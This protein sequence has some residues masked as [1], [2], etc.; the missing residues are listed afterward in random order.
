M[1]FALLAPVFFSLTFAL[2]FHMFTT[3]QLNHLD[4]AV[5]EAATDLKLQTTTARSAS[6][7]KDTYLCPKA[8]ILMSC[9]NLEVGV[10]SDE[11][12][13]EIQ[14]WLGK[15]ITGK[16]CPGDKGDIVVLSARYEITGPFKKLYIGA[17][18]QE[19]EKIFLSSRYFVV[20]EPVVTGEGISC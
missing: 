16:F 14:R 17:M 12:L 2:M 1:E 4:Y 7:F 20:R 10:D 5:Y 13:I 9:D 6:E 18:Q 8:G 3:I 19:D 15:D 11:N